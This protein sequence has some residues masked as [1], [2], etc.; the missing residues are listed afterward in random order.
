M[1]IPFF[2]YIFAKL[3]KNNESRF[4]R[5]Q[6]RM[7]QFNTQ[8]STKLEEPI[9]PLVV[10]SQKTFSVYSRAKTTNLPAP[11]KNCA[12]WKRYF[13]IALLVG[14]LAGVYSWV[15]SQVLTDMRIE[16]L[17]G[18]QESEVEPLTTYWQ[19][20]NSLVVQ[21]QNELK[22]GIQQLSQSRIIEK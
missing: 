22:R 17:K 5:R 8:Q 13:G 18:I 11:R 9:L 21:R 20:V 6:T 4:R 2:A 14:F 7:M 15:E 19:G 1:L 16:I 3:V 12:L 10:I